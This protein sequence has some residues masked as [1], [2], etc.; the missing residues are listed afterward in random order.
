[1]KKSFK[2]IDL[3]P[4]IR[5]MLAEQGFTV[6]GE[7]KGCDIAAVRDDALWLI[8]MKLSANLKLL[9]QAAA[10]QGMTDWVFVAVP[11][12][13]K[14][15]DKHFTQYARL[16]KR[17]NIGLITVSLDSEYPMAS[18]IHFPE[19]NDVKNNAASRKVKREAAGRTIDTCGGSQKEVNTV[20]REKCIKIAA[21]LEIHAPLNA[22]ALMKDHGCETDTYNILRTNSYGWYE[23]AGRGTYVLTEKC[24]E[25]LK[26]NSAQNL[27]IFYRMRAAS[28]AH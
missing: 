16:L 14:A 18:V 17:L 19:G 8:E 27:V 1:M 15:R 9:F 20:Y 6:R 24:R 25:Y 22:P 13:G 23:K 4:P 5:K 26:E 21:L 7:V 10:K 11:R 2:E 12:P 28:S 3:Y